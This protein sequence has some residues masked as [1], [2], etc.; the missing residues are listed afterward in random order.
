MF[1]VLRSS[2][3]KS[4]TKAS[5]WGYTYTKSARLSLQNMGR[6]VELSCYFLTLTEM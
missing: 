1:K 2:S 5:S 6:N 3:K 4:G